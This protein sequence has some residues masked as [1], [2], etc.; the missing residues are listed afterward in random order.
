MLLR[1]ISVGVKWN[2]AQVNQL[3]FLNTNNGKFYTKITKITKIDYLISVTIPKQNHCR[4]GRFKSEKK[5]VTL[6]EVQT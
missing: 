6:L 3:I 2:K 4:Y 5:E 1:K